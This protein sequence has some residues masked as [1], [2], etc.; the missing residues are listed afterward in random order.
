MRNGEDR[1]KV[2]EILREAMTHARMERCG[3]GNICAPSAPATFENGNAITESN[4]T[5]FIKERTRLW[6]E[7]WLISAIARVQNILADRDEWDG[8]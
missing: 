8:L 1:R 3:F 6:R 4:V 7:S 2:D 5:D